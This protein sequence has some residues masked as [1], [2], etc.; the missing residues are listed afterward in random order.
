MIRH[1]QILDAKDQVIGTTDRNKTSE[2]YYHVYLNNKRSAYMIK[3]SERRN[4]LRNPFY[5]FHPVHTRETSP[6]YDN[7]TYSYELARLYDTLNENEQNWIL[8]L[9]IYEAVYYGIDFTQ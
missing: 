4:I 3:N 7:E 5:D 2:E 1:E 8:A 9:V 6:W